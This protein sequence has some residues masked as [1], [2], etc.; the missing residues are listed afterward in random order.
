MIYFTDDH[1]SI[2]N[3]N[4]II[5][6]PEYPNGALIIGSDYRISMCN[7]TAAKMF[8][9]NHTDEFVG[10]HITEFGGDCTS[11]WDS[12]QGEFSDEFLRKGFAKSGAAFTTTEGKIWYG[13]MSIYKLTPRPSQPYAAFY[14][15]LDI[16]KVDF[17]EKPMEEILH[18]VEAFTRVLRTLVEPLQKEL[19]ASITKTE[20][21]IIAL[22]KQGLSTKEIATGLC[23][24]H[25]TVDNHRHSIRQKL[26][27]Q[28]GQTLQ[29]IL[30]HYRA[31]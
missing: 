20:R 23:V 28:S 15:I 29:Q 31:K 2:E 4:T 3:L 27:I 10:T 30:S 11:V 12:V 5:N 1:K 18:K 16:S 24:S 13:I 22:L 14:D 26:N 8:G 19:P 7:H 21:E 25:K 17:L 6:N 9:H